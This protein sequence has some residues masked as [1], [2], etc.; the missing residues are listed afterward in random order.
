MNDMKAPTAVANA[1]F[2]WFGGGIKND[3]TVAA[4]ACQREVVAMQCAGSILNSLFVDF[5]RNEEKKKTIK[6]A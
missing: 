3:N 6:L 2:G 4:A 5:K 1:F